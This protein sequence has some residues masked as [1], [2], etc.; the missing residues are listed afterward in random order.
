VGGL[1]IGAG[2]VWVANMNPRTVTR[3]D[4]ETNAI[5][6]TISLGEP[7]YFWGPT[8]LAFGHGSVWALDA[9]SS[10]VVRIDPQSNR[11]TTTIPLGSPTQVS[12]GPLGLVVTSDAAWVA[13]TWGTTEAPNGSVVRIDPQTNRIV[14]R[15]ALGSA[16]SDSGPV[17]VAASDDA[18]WASVPS[19]RSVVR[20]DPRT[21]SAVAE[22]PALACAHGQLAADE[23]SLWVADCTS[24][25]RID[26]RTNVLTLTVPMPR[27]TGAG[28][29][30][31]AV[32]LGSVWVQAGPLVRI[33]PASGTVMSVLP[34]EP[35]VNDCAYSIAFGF[36]SVWV[37]QHDRVV[38]IRPG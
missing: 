8:R 31:V 1:T 16:P 14:A 32:G 7:D 19:T 28:V 29:L 3:I 37:R 30:G 38:R 35:V 17:G 26:L 36:D 25:R 12:T 20:I 18:V 33:D 5:V 23:S 24:I 13:N 6:A 4:P 10:S 11:I 2:S 27:A 34:L 15:I 22:V 9:M 21:G